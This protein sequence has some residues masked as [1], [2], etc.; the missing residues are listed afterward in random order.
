MEKQELEKEIG[1]DLETVALKLKALSE[2]RGER[3]IIDWGPLCGNG[4]FYTQEIPL[5]KD[6][7]H[8][9]SSDTSKMDVFVEITYRGTEDYRLDVS[10]VSPG[11]VFHSKGPGPYYRVY[12]IGIKGL[13]MGSQFAY[14]QIH[15]TWR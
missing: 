14:G 13:G 1:R 4:L 8:V 2:A 6:G 5:G 10:P 3:E 12:A 9:T 11:G 7:V 15:W